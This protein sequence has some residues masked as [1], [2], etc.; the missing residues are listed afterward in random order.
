MVDLQSINFSGKKVLVRADLNVPI[1]EDGKITDDNRIRQSVPTI[2]L[3]LEKGGLPIVMSH[4]GRP[5][6][7]PEAKFSLKPVAKKLEE[8]LKTDIVLAPD[9]IGPKV[10]EIV[11]AQSAGQ[12]VLL[13]NLRFHKGEKENNEQFARELASLADV[14]VNDA[15]AAAHRSHASIVGVPKF[16]K[17]NAPGLLMG[18]EIEYFR[19]ALLKPERP[20][21]VVLGGAKVS[22]KLNALLNLADKADKVVVGGAMANTFLAAQGFQMGRSLYEQGLFPKVI[23]LIGQ[24]A[25]RG[26]QL[27]L[28]VDFI[29]APSLTSVGLERAVP[30]QEIPADLMALDI[31]PATSLLYQ[32]ALKTA[33]TIVWNG[34]MGAFE[35]EPF[36]KGTTDMIEYLASSHGLTVVGGG[37]TDAAIHQMELGH[38]FDYISTGGGAFLA[39]ME[40]VPLPAFRALGIELQ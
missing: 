29:V 27:Y 8:L 22:T 17:E 1:D 32:E 4:L 38:K 13:E 2:K 21:C 20:L 14:Y 26:C 5:G 31:G 15:F 10:T 18:K 16:T 7:K 33:Q 28:P 23:E 11:K 24:L 9:C 37:D 34:P 35:K 6:G 40:G 3:I 30:A 12:V 36:S 19:K 25:R 39:L